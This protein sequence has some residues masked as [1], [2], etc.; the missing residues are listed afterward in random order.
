[1]KCNTIFLLNPHEQQDKLGFLCPSCSSKVLTH[2]AVQ[3]SSCQTVLNF[4]RAAALE[5]K[6]TFSIEK[7]SHCVGTV[8]DEWEIEPLYSSGFYM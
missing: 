3:C 7:C 2:H 5:E 4:V 6:V 1:M 8:E